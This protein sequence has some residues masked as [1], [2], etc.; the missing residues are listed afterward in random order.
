VTFEANIS[1]YLL[2]CC[3]SPGYGISLVAETT[4]GCLI[5][6]EGAATHPK[7]D[8]EENMEKIG[9]VLPEDIG[10]QAVTQ[11]LEEVKQGGVIDSTHQVCTCLSQLYWFLSNCLLLIDCWFAQY[12]HFLVCEVS[13]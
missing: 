10:L 7:A 12:V 5:S 4:T 8:G 2:S 1:L 3:R 9:P 13:L 6:A 11:L